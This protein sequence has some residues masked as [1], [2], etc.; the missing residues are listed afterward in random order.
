MD[1]ILDLV[2]TKQCPQTDQEGHGCTY[3]HTSLG[4][5]CTYV[6]TCIPYIQKYRQSLNLAICLKSGRNA[7]L[8][9][10]KFGRLLCY[11]IA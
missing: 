3:V 8:V 7:L 11:I 9:E 2:N 10:F 6:H 5:L 1:G 4:V